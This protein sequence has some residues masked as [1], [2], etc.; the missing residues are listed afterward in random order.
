MSDLTSIHRQLL[1]DHLKTDASKPAKD[2]RT[3]YYDRVVTRWVRLEQRTGDRVVLGSNP[4]SAISLRNFC[5]SVY[6]ILPVVSSGG[7][8]KKAIGPFYLV[9]MLH[10]AGVNL[11]H[12]LDTTI[13]R[14]GQL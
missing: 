12:V 4:A 7:D 11:K 5:N 8:N 10:T 2:R 3:I 9:S 13:L 1:P 14:E 6:P